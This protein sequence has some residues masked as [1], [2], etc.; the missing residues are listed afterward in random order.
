MATLKVTSY[1]N[2][3]TKAVPFGYVYFNDDTRMGFAQ[4][5]GVFVANWGG[6][7]SR[8]VEMALAALKEVGIDLYV[9]TA[10]ATR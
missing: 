2:R 5:R 7:T 8:H 1:E 3:G 4:D 6:G 10:N 9:Q